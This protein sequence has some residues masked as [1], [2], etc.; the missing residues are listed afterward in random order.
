MTEDELISA[1]IDNDLGQMNAAE[2]TAF[3]A[4]LRDDA[5]LRRQVNVTRLLAAEAKQLDAVALPRNFIL[6]RD[7]PREQK[8]QS[9]QPQPQQGSWLPTWIF[10]F[11]SI[12]AA[13]LFVVLIGAE[14]LGLQSRATSVPVSMLESTSV[15]IATVQVDAPMA[16]TA[17]I[18]TPLA[19]EAQTQFEATLNPAPDASAMSSMPDASDASAASAANSAAPAPESSSVRSMPAPQPQAKAAQ[20]DVR[21]YS[22]T[23]PQVQSQAAPAEMSAPA[24][25][26]V[27]VATPIPAPPEVLQPSHA[28]AQPA[29][30]ITPARVIAVM[31]LLVALILG[32]LGW[33]RRP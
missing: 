17:I 33:L 25:E 28:P 21:P 19:Q 9:P 26:A 14:S 12:A 27:P 23:L 24:V 11:G 22:D 1:Y 10:R 29:Q 5:V 13:G 3:E 7:M 15:A 30:V 16:M 31:A 20:T 18:N 6:P 4:R 8:S 2:R 32:A